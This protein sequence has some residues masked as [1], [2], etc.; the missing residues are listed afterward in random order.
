MSLIYMFC[1][2]KYHCKNRYSI[3]TSMFYNKS[4]CSQNSYGEVTNVTKDR[5]SMATDIVTNRY[6]LVTS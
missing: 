2:N 3:A 4:I 6:L 1:D 5:I